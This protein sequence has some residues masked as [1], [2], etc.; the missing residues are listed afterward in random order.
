MTSQP[1]KK[2][3]HPSLLLSAEDYKASE[4]LANAYLK[5]LDTTG[6]LG[7]EEQTFLVQL[8]YGRVDDFM[9][10]SKIINELH[11][12]LVFQS[13]YKGSSRASRLL[14]KYEEEFTMCADIERVFEN[15]P[16]IWQDQY[17]VTQAYS[18]TQCEPCIPCSKEEE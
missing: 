17:H 5:I 4:A 9:R 15:K 1:K 2:Y 3:L 8:V 16:Y 10:F 18:D 11:D 12:F 14:Q 7:K 13:S 6:S